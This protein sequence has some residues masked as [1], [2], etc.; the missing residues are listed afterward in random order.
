M[1][2]FTC[3]LYLKKYTFD[4][5]TAHFLR[6]FVDLFIYSTILRMSVWYGV[7]TQ[8]IIHKYMILGEREKH[9]WGDCKSFK[10]FCSSS[11]AVIVGLSSS[12]NLRCISISE[13]RVRHSLL[14]VACPSAN[15]TWSRSQCS[16]RNFVSPTN[17]VYR[18]RS[19]INLCHSNIIH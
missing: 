10:V 17:S 16:R 14:N 7:N 6:Q 9:Q 8:I 5:R 13:L 15:W 12:L 19:S 2:E 1:S 18:K 4:W 3:I 11:M